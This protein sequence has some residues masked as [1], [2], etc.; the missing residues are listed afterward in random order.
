V[1]NSYVAAG[2]FDSPQRPLRKKKRQ[3]KKTSPQRPLRTQRKKK[4]TTDWGK[5]GKAKTNDFT[6][7]NA[8]NNRNDLR[9]G[10]KQRKQLMPL[11]FPEKTKRTAR[12]A[13]HFRFPP[14]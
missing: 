14:V 6:A 7:E 4:R 8:E 2:Q 13:R 10:E 3:R 5:N 11:F 9:M 12:V 1:Y